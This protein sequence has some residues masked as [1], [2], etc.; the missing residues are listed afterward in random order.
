M[1]GPLGSPRLRPPSAL[2]CVAPTHARAFDQSVRL[3]ALKERTKASNYPSHAALHCNDSPDGRWTVEVPRGYVSCGFS[4]IVLDRRKL[5]AAAVLLL[6]GN[7]ACWTTVLLITDVVTQQRV[8]RGA[9]RHT[10]INVIS[11]LVI[12]ALCSTPHSHLIIRSL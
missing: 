6:Y 9:S 4:S 3:Q 12:R 8:L 10:T 7:I 11:A 1:I 2:H 5:R